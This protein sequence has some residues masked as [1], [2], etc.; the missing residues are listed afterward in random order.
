MVVRADAARAVALVDRCNDPKQL[1][2][3]AANARK[4]GQDSI[5]RYA[6]LK[7]YRTLPAA[8]PGTFEHDVWQSIHALEGALKRERGKTVRLARTRDKI[9]RLG[10]HRT[11]SDLMMA[12]KPS[13]GY[14]MLIYCGMVAQTFEAVVLRHPDRF[15]E[16][17]RDAAAMRLTGSGADPSQF[18]GALR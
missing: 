15:Q 13:D 18:A 16:S 7:L 2:Q 3:I 5:E 9:K 1:E 6:L 8:D 4:A 10:E 12:A 11:V 17:Q 14:D